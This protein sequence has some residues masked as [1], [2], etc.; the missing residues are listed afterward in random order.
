MNPQILWQQ[1][2]ACPCT[3]QMNLFLSSYDRDRT[4]A[5]LSIDEQQTENTNEQ[6]IIIYI[7]MKCG[8]HKHG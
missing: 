4:N 5:K 8:E 6:V 2:R 1:K 3:P 7:S